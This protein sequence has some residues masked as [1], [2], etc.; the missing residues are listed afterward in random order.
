MGKMW[1]GDEECDTY[2]LAAFLRCGSLITFLRASFRDVECF[3]WYWK[4][5]KI[6]CNRTFYNQ[7]LMLGF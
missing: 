6:Y 4:F 3:Y 1:Q 2:S 5:L 7:N